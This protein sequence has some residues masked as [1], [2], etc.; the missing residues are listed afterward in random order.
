M[1]SR[2][3]SCGTAGKDGDMLS[4]NYTA[5]DRLVRLLQLYK[6][7]DEAQ[8]LKETGR[9]SPTQYVVIRNSVQG[10]ID[11]CLRQIDLLANEEL[12]KP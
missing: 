5:N 1:K 10:E 6:A 12:A 7:K 4:I 8:R 9:L 2:R 3:P 11:L